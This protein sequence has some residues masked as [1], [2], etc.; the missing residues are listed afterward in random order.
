MRELPD[1]FSLAAFEREVADYRRHRRTIRLAEAHH[2]LGETLPLEAI[3]WIPTW[4]LYE[5]NEVDG[6]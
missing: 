2:R 5:R 4:V 3:G 1:M 6:A